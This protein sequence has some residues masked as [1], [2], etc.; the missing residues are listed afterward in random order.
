MVGFD[1]Q[2]ILGLTDRHRGGP[3][4]DF[5]EHALVFGVQVLNH[6]KTQAGRRREMLQEQLQGFQAAGRGSNADN[7]EQDSAPLA[8]LRPRGAGSPQS[9]LGRARCGIE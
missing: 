8:W 7:G 9:S 6:H 4:Q 5:H 1:Q 2:P 3:G